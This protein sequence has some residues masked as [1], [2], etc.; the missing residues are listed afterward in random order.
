LVEALVAAR[1]LPPMAGTKR[2]AEGAGL[3]GFESF[4]GLVRQ[5]VLAE[6]ERPDT[7]YGLEPRRARRRGPGRGR[8]PPRRGLDRL[9][10]ALMRL[11]ALLRKQLEDP[12]NP[13]D[14]TARQRLDAAIRGVERRAG[15]PARRLERAA[16]ATFG[17]TAA[18][19]TVE[20]L[21]L[22]RF[23]GNETDIALNR[24]WID[25]AFL[26]CITSRSRRTASSLTSATLTDGEP[27]RCSPGASPRRRAGCAI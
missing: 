26:S 2:V 16:A 12:E 22:D 23:E 15:G 13:P 6:V 24:N 17:E 11:V 25:P 10:A 4:L 9:A 21:A 27:T 18:A 20:W 1:T 3:P 19:E 14:P 8:R 5:Q 7:G